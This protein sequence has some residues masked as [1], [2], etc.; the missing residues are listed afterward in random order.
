M[1]VES[2]YLFACLVMFG[3]QTEQDHS[4]GFILPIAYLLLCDMQHLFVYSFVYKIS[5]YKETETNRHAVL[6]F[7]LSV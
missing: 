7:Y 6:L 4:V 5:E 3:R 2:V 1:F